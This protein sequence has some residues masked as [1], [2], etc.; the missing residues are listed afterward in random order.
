MLFAVSGDAYDR[1]MGR[2]SIP[3]ALVF[4]DFAGIVRGIGALDVGCGPG[5]LTSELVRRL[6]AESVAAAD[7]S[8]QFVTVC[9]ER[10]PDVEVRETPA[11]QLPWP[12]GV[13]DAALAQLVISFVGD[14]PT[15]AGEMR[16]VV[17]PGG[18][19]AACMWAAESGGMEMLHAF[20]EAA[21]EL[22]ADAPDESRMRYRTTG[23]LRELGRRRGSTA[24]RP[25]P[26]T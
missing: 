25:A 20:W 18:I 8:P 15:A 11:E 2:Y 19:V 22:N 5:A 14:A 26:S 6:G 4:A 23:E 3:L 12:D 7:P 16:R 1:F 17:R 10:L 21:R 24:L 13:F 9:R